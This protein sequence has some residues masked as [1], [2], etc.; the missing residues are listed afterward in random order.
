MIKDSLTT[1]ELARLYQ[2]YVVVR[3]RAFRLEVYKRAR[4]RRTFE[5]R[6]ECDVA[7]GQVGHETR[8][9]PFFVMAKAT[10]PV[11]TIPDSQWVIDAG[12]TPGDRV[13][14]GAPENPI[15]EAFLRFT[16]DGIGIHGTDN[17]RS[18]HSRASHGCVRVSP[19]HA[20]WLYMHVPVGSPVMVI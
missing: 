7:I 6:W 10:N 17:L 12:L 19:E 9:G 11:W 4:T 1:D 3:R 16:D 15:K 18:I 20:R 5:Q 8:P 2:T 13:P 14:G